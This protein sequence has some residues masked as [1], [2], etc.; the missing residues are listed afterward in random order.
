MLSALRYSSDPAG[1][2]GESSMLAFFDDGQFQVAD[3]TDTGRRIVVDN[4]SRIILN[5]VTVEDSGF[6]QCRI[7]YRSGKEVEKNVHLRIGVAPTIEPFSDMEVLEETSFKVVCHTQGKPSV[8][9]F[10]HVGTLNGVVWQCEDVKLICEMA[11][12]HS[13][14]VR[15]YR[16]Y[17]NDRLITEQRDSGVFSISRVAL[18]RDGIYACVPETRLGLG[19]NK[20][21]RLRVK[22]APKLCNDISTSSFNFSSNTSSTAKPVSLAQPKEA[23]RSG[24]AKGNAGLNAS[25]ILILSWLFLSLIV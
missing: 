21:L 17:Q 14:R 22:A 4:S 8:R 6:Y 15:N 18:N 1:L 7:D 19:R 5:N 3:E 25:F 12:N 9:E 16:L 2:T 23:G 20:T 11:P 13:L 10:Y 24:F